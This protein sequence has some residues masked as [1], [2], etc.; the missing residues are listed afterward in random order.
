MLQI[1]TQQP[2]GKVLKL[3]SGLG[4]FAHAAVKVLRKYVVTF[5]CLQVFQSCVSKADWKNVCNGI[6]VSVFVH[7]RMLS[8][9]AAAT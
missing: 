4:V 1:C 6:N 5:S 9:Y 8:Q 7:P 2:V 3:L